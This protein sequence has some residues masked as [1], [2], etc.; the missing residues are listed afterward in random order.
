MANQTPREHLSELIKDT[1]FAM[2]T[3][4]HGSNGHLHA[5]PMTT[6]NSEIEADDSLWFFMS[7][8][9]GTASDL[10]G[11]VDVN[12]SY[13]NPD[14]DR[15]VSVSG[16][17][18][19]VENP[20]KAQALWNKMAEAWFKGPDDPELALVRVAITHAHYWDVKES[21]LVQLYEMA[22]AALTGKPPTNLGES[23]EVRLR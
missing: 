2:F 8:R 18:S 22:K 1:R 12:I 6:Q 23:G 5:S 13:A 11:E 19:I 10:V 3:T 17:A 4:R 16:R 9:S 15:Y 7:R 21:K 20:A 14:S